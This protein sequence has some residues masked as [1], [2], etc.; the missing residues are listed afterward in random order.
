MAIIQSIR[1]RAGVLLA[2]VVGLA[3]LA[4]V[5]G[6]FI[7]SGGFLYSR[8][9]QNVAEINGK[10]VGYP[11]F[12]NRILYIEK[13]LKAQYRVS[14]LDQEMAESAR[15]QAWQELLQEMILQ[16]EYD[17]L[18]LKV[19]YPEFS[20]L[21]QG[22]NPHPIIMQMFANPETGTLDR[23]QLSEF[24]NKIEDIPGEP[25]LVWVYYEKL[26]T[27]ERLYNK[28][29]NLLRKGVYVNS[30]EAKRR[31]R[32]I[33]TSVDFSF[34]QKSYSSLADSAI[35]VSENEIKK[36]YKEHKE[37]YKQEESRDIK[38]VAFQVVP[39]QKDYRDAETW[40]HDI[41]PEFE[42][43]ED[44]K[45]YVNYT[46]PPYDNTNYKK[47]ELPDSLDEFMFSAKLGDVYGPY[48]E[49]NAYK[50]A[51]LAKI[52]YLPD[53]VKVSQIYLPATQAN[54]QQMK[55]LADSL[56]KMARQ[57]YN[58][59]ELVRQNSRDMNSV[60]N[61]GDLGWIKE[62]TKGQTF[63]DSC[64]Y[65][66]KSD[67]KLTLSQEGF[68]IVK[69][70]DM[71]RRVKK[72]QVGI[73]S[74]EVT[75]G[76]ETDQKYYKQAVDFLNQNRTLDKFEQSVADNDP[77]AIPVYDIKPL[78]KEIQGLGYARDVIRWAFEEAGEGDVYNDVNNYGGKYVVFIVTKVK[79][80]GYMP[81]KDVEESIRIEIIKRKKAEKLSDELLLAMADSKSI[82]DIATKTGEEVKSVTGIRFSSYS[83]MEAGAEPKLIGAAIVAELDELTGP[84][85]GE[86][87]VYIFSVD[88]KNETE[89]PSS[90]LKITQSYIE[91]S[92]AARVNRVAF[93]KLQDLA[94]IKDYRGRFF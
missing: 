10:R 39:S 73:L 56:V 65:A 83:V 3:L 30:L 92:Y 29:L 26:I 5:L 45:Q 77:M 64:F 62:G 43:I 61:N 84:I 23:L 31:Q 22:P 63:S 52:D 48:F 86:N 40:I 33:N 81:L 27:A 15:T 20:D 80:A 88:N 70:I 36:Y 58:F 91:R 42:E 34:I 59:A 14:T 32:D 47:G 49:D 76:T 66:E 24:L 87:G 37:N 2:V 74:R 60:M 16:K 51:K 55:Q 94:H 38:Y 71:S 89:N 57:G 90:D 12:Q 68:H 21:V 72:V 67:V 4:F 7:T 11:T 6:D 69:I 9:K 35:T 25:K 85:K 50:L 41:K 54:V 78:D 75:P 17:R 79:N 28:Y 93:D 82:D 46:S 1:N 53:S 19:S 8:S 44:V 13:V 18:G